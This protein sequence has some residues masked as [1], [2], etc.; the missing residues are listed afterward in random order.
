MNRRSVLKSLAGALGGLS[1]GFH[2]RIANAAHHAGKF[3]VSVQADGGWDPTNF[4]DPKTNTPG[5][6]DITHWSDRDDIQQVGNI[7]YAPFGN[8][9]AF[10]RKHFNRMLVINGVDAQTNSHTVGVTHNWSG[11]N[12]EGFPTITAVAAANQADDLPAPYL[13]F[14]G[15]SRTA[16]ITRYTRLD[17]PNQVRNI[18]YPN[19]SYS[20]RPY[21]S[22]ENWHAL[23]D[24]RRKTVSRLASRS[25]VTPAEKYR[26]SLYEIAISNENLMRFADA[27]P[28]NSELENSIES[29]AIQGSANTHRSNLRRQAQ[30][31]VIAFATETS[32]SADLHQSGFDTHSTHDPE[33]RWLL[34]RL[35]DGIDYLWEYAAEW[36]IDD[37]LVVVIGSDFS[38][39][40]FYNSNDGKDHWPIGS[41]IVMEN[42]QRWTNR[43]VEG[44]DY[45]QF[46]QKVNP[47]TLQPDANDG[48]IIYPKH[49]HKALRRHLGINDTP[50]AM[51]HPFNNVED[52]AFFDDMS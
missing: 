10:F 1:A 20:E 40:N 18:A 34:D 29:G 42:N 17:N 15:F 5:E 22:A 46:A 12:S 8:N 32:V 35:T 51:A 31:A 3:V 36:G 47:R 49:V 19:L 9:A 33:S 50:G 11:R 44:T 21:V 26:L 30:M 24:Y 39:T 41:F 13:S 14:G 7:P 25:N 37:R 28:P 48:T 2:L 45:L 6:P 23:T 16:G 38:R 52:F 27:I 43:M 4:C